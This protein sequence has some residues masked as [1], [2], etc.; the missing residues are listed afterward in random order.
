MFLGI[1]LVYL[2]PE[3][4]NHRSYWFPPQRALN[5]VHMDFLVE[6]EV[7]GSCA[8]HFP[9]LWAMPDS[10]HHVII[11]YH[12]CI[13]VCFCQILT[14]KARQTP[15][16]KEYVD[17][18]E[19]KKTHPWQCFFLLNTRPKNEN[20]PHPHPMTDLQEQDRLLSIAWAQ[21]RPDSNGEAMKR[22]RGGASLLVA[23]GI[24]T[25]SKD[26]TR[27]SWPRY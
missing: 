21:F 22:S 23:K 14:S 20:D 16:K 10:H 12:P 7:S 5:L 4:W 15:E 9:L 6:P 25:R 13:W 26:A 8:S 27:G 2:E 24:A 3:V 19:S 17:T 11:V 1:R 18:Y